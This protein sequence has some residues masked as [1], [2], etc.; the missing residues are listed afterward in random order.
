MAFL[1]RPMDMRL[2]KFG[3]KSSPRPSAFGLS[4]LKRHLFKLQYTA[5]FLNHLLHTINSSV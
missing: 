5:I 4:L 1:L 3:L 2:M